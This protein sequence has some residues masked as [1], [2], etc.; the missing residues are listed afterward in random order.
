MEK[1]G[2]LSSDHIDQYPCWRILIHKLWYLDAFPCVE[3]SLILIILMCF[4]KR[5][6]YSVVI[7][8]GEMR[9]IEIEPGAKD[10][11]LNCIILNKQCHI[12][13]TIFIISGILLYMFDN[14]PYIVNL[15]D[16][17]LHCY[18]TYCESVPSSLDSHEG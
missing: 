18:G 11:A 9:D 17:A 15:K 3:V 12:T 13:I 5:L 7:A 10:A 14:L 6:I 2:R 16:W 8:P 4:C 1:G